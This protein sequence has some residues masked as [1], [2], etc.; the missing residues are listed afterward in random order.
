[1]AFAKIM[2]PEI[3]EDPVVRE[4]LDWVTQMEGA[5]HGWAGRAR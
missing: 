5:A 1:M 4:I 3:V 2:K